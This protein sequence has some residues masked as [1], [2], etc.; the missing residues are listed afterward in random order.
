LKLD[1]I[2][3]ELNPER[4]MEPKGIL[5]CDDIMEKIGEEFKKIP[6]KR[7][8]KMK[9]THIC[10]RCKQ[11]QYT[12]GLRPAE[13]DSATDWKCASFAATCLLDWATRR[14]E[15][16]PVHFTVSAEATATT[17]AP[18]IIVAIHMYTLACICDSLNGH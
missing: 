17:A 1:L 13:Y 2:Y 7:I 8:D 11:T 5:L 10:R 4:E 9:H 18:V 14:L 3:L 6:N 12:L 15:Y 16:Q